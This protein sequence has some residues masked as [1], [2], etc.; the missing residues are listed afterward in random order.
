YSRIPFAA[1]RDGYFFK[2]FSRLHPKHNFPHVSLLV[3]GVIAIIC[4]FFSL[5]IV[6]DVL[7]ATRIIVQFAGQIFA[8]A[9]LR[10]NSPKMERPY[11]IWLYPLPSLIALTGWMFIYLTLGP[12]IIIFSL[13]ALAAGAVSFLAWSRS[14]SKWPF[15]APSPIP[16]RSRHYRNQGVL[17]WRFAR[18]SRGGNVKPM[19]ISG[20]PMMAG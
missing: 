13:V 1:A 14:A 3:I 12:V 4:S 9:L 7:I 10:K 19:V 8:V 6:I 11:R 2:V 16:N 17:G 18:K 15:T 5:G 20:L